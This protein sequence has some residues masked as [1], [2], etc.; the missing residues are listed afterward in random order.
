MGPTDSLL[1]DVA[2]ICVDPFD[3]IYFCDYAH[4]AIRAISP[5][6]YVYTLVCADE[7]YTPVSFAFSAPFGIH[8]DR[9]AWAANRPCLYVVDFHRLIRIDLDPISLPSPEA[10]LTTG[11]REN[12]PA[13]PN[14]FSI[15]QELEMISKVEESRMDVSQP[16]MGPEHPVAPHAHDAFEQR[17]VTSVST[18]PPR[19]P[20]KPKCVLERV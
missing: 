15:D 6:G 10:P 9:F 17:S 16:H 13:N 2:G 8:F 3:T 1:G 14:Q 11:R 19:A 7:S 18:R 4:G 5:E 20:P 12:R